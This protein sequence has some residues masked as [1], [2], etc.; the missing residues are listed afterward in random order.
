MKYQEAIS[1]LM[2]EQSMA[3][4]ISD[5]PQETWHVRVSEANAACTQQAYWVAR[6]H[7]EGIIDEGNQ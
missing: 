7:K 5:Y 4:I 1:W 6:A 2:G 3:N